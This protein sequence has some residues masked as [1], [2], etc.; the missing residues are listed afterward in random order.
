MT[1]ANNV[2]GVAPGSLRRA[3]NVDLSRPNLAQCRR[4]FDLIDHSLPSADD[5]ATK[6]FLYDTQLFATYDDILGIYDAITGWTSKGSLIKPT[7]AIVARTVSIIDNL[8]VASS[9]GLKKLDDTSSSLYP[10]GIIKGLNM[11]LAIGATG[12]ALATGESVAYRYVLGRKDATN[13][14][15]RGGVSAAQTISNSTG[16]TKDITVTGYLPTGIDNTYFVELYRTAGTTGTPNDEMQKCY[17]YPLTNTDISNGYFTITDIVPD[18]LLKDALYTSPSQQGIAQDNSYPPVAADIC[19]HKGY[20][21]FADIEDKHRYTV[22]LVACGGTGLVVNDTFTISDGVTT[23][24]Y[25]AKAA[26]SVGSKQFLVDTASS[27][28]AT[29]IDTTSRS[30]VNVI[31]RGSTLVYAYLLATGNDFPGQIVIERRSTGAAFTVVSSRQPAWSPQLQATS[32]ANQTSTNDAFRNGLR[33]SK[34]GEPESVPLGNQLRVGSS[35]DP[36]VRIISSKDALFIFK[37]RGGAFILRGE[38]ASSWQL[39]ELDSTCKVVSAESIVQL[40][41]LIYGLFESGICEVSDT[42]VAII[43]DPIKDKILTL[44]GTALQT[45]RD[46][47]FG[48]SYETD[49]KYILFLPTTSA[50]TCSTYQLVYDINN[51][52]FYEWDLNAQSAVVS[53]EDTNLHYAAGNSNKIKIERKNYDYTD[54]ADFEQE[55]TISSYSGYDIQLSGYDAMSV[56][57]LLIQNDLQP[58]YITAIDLFTGTVTLDVAVDWDTGDTVDHYKAI[59]IEI[60]WN[61]DFAGNVGGLKKFGE[62]SLIFQKNIIQTGMLTFTGDAGQGSHSVEIAGPSFNGAWGYFAWGDGTWGDDSSPFPIRRAIPRPV[63]VCSKLVV[64]FTHSVAYSEWQLQG[65]S[66]VFTPMSTRISRGNV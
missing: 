66:L 17:E 7:N 51:E 52:V 63:A 56:G 30:L 45:V 34:R 12:T 65:L 8:Y 20:L 1:Y 18:D 35:D 21:F 43:S 15:I 23:E 33:W 32:N 59:P 24:V 64:K 26:E 61:P 42:A 57:D 2:S 16:A 54:F 38:D 11:T 53:T 41:G 31:N 29:R 58:A 39:S 46:Y 22:T 6:L 48:V 44:Y 40:N 28:I 3:M 50:D 5:R 14:T 49:G 27:S 55:S 13:H 9:S 62:C 37:R 47:S 25:T 19:E 4:G 60:E 10:A 36:I